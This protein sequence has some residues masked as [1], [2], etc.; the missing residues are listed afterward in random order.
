MHLATYSKSAAGKMLAHYERSIGERD[1]IDSSIP[2]YNLAPEYEGGCHARF[3]SL[4]E[5][6]D[7]DGKSK[8]LADF[9]VT[10]PS[11][12]EDDTR[13]F[14][15]AAYDELLERVGSDR[16]VCA[17]VHPDEPGARPHMHFAFVPIVETP[18]M[19]ND[20]TQPLLWTKSDEKRNRAHKAG[21]QKTD[22][23]GTKRWKRV[24][25]LDENG[26]PV[27][28]RTATASKL[29]SRKEMSELHPQ[30]ESAL[31][32]RLGVDRVGLTLDENDP[33]KVLSSLHHDQYER[34]TEEI[35]RQE[36]RLERLRQ[37]GDRAEKRVA[38]LES[39]AAETRLIDGAGVGAKGSLLSAFANRCYRLLAAMIHSMAPAIREAFSLAVG[40][41]QSRGDT[42]VS[43][44]RGD[45]VEHKQD[46]TA[47]E[48]AQDQ[49]QYTPEP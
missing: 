16:V 43:V 32:A 19:V 17:Y 22:T 49:L 33:K 25:K 47:I 37:D 38:A 12:Y 35:K 18:V 13:E 21:T 42:L 48:V 40:G 24:P 20:K 5:G 44:T 36:Q 39:V 2:V 26:V 9:V 10:M 4:C 14:F 30:M 34:V 11:E 7:L 29:F 23:K 28:R 6:L 1:H 15:Q 3:Y 27:M 41:I 46:G 8:P 45:N 31:C